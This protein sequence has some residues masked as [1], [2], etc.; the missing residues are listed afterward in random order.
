MFALKFTW[1]PPVAQ[2]PQTKSNI[3][4]V[5]LPKLV[6]RKLGRVTDSPVLLS[7]R[8]TFIRGRNGE[9]MLIKIEVKYKRPGETA[10]K[11]LPD[12]K[13]PKRNCH[14]A[15][16]VFCCWWLVGFWFFWQEGG[17]YSSFSKASV[18]FKL[19]LGAHPVGMGFLKLP[20][21]SLV[22]HGWFG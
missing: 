2:L 16:K 6:C 21:C 22:E 19:A 15:T 20:F 13:E 10:F 18:W 3:C 9:K 4:I 5:L 12:Q 8:I 17:Y 7:L 14:K 11:Y 1:H